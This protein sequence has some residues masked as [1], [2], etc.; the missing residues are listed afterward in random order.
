MGM[1]LAH[2]L[3]HC[4][5]LRKAE[6]ACIKVLPK[7]RDIG[8]INDS[9]MW[10]MFLHPALYKTGNLQFHNRHGP[11]HWDLTVS[12][13]LVPQV[14]VFVFGLACTACLAS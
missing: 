3:Q 13:T 5:D 2:M 11:Q 14:W 6:A 12:M 8:P 7:Q 9:A 10:P 1:L 4:L